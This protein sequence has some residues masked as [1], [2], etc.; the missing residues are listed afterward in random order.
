MA[1]TINAEFMTHTCQNRPF[2]TAKVA[3]SMDGKIA[4]KNGESKYISGTH[5]LAYVHQ[6]RAKSNAIMIGIGTLLADNPQLNS[7]LSIGSKSLKKIILDAKARTPL[8][9]RIFENTTPTDVV[10]VTAQ[11][12]PTDAIAALEKKA[13]VI[14]ISAPH[15]N[16]E[17]HQFL[18]KLR[19]M[20]IYSIL[21]EGGE[22]V[23]SDAID[24]D[25]VDRLIT[26]TSPKLLGGK[27]S[28]SMYAGTKVQ[29]LNEAILLHDVRYRRVG[30]DMITSGFIHNPMDF[31]QERELS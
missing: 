2:I 25:V 22:T 10:I 3:T 29:H 7:R 14:T 31:I 12:A 23:L 19:D 13:T 30:D 4:L 5:S 26:I 9:S 1:A 8:D 20:G 16:G 15:L 18:P 27:S 11:H 28:F 21:L 24:S 6:L 17:W